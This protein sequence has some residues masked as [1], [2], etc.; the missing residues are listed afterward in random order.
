MKC[1]VIAGIDPGST[2]SSIAV[3]VLDEDRWIARLFREFENIELI[4]RL[5]RGHNCGLIEG[6]GPHNT[7]LTIEEVKCYGNPVGDDVLQTVFWSGRFAQAW[8]RRCRMIPRATVRAHLSRISTAQKGSVNQ[9]LRD[10][11]GKKG[12]KKNPGLLYACSYHCW[13][14]LAVAVTAGE[15]GVGGP[16]VQVVDEL[17]RIVETKEESNHASETERTRKESKA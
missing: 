2:K 9:A 17:R 12:T 8:G 4:S 15:R 5:M 11:Y 13:E 6:I 10:R 14:A 16:Y 3:L 7:L 1:T